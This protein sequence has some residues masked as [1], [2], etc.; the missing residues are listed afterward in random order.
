VE[1]WASAAKQLNQWDALQEYAASAGN[2]ALLADSY[3][4][5][6]EW[7]RLRDV[8][9]GAFLLGRGEGSACPHTPAAAAFSMQC[10]KLNSSPHPHPPHAPARQMNKQATIEPGPQS[11]LIRAYASLQA[12]GG[13]GD[14]GCG[15][16]ALANWLRAPKAQTPFNPLRPLNLM[17]LTRRRWT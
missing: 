1:Q 16:G 11:C 17:P 9:V 15:V 4:R 8:L 3:W 13:G 12:R 7:D 5:L 6:S 10:A 2:N 14:A